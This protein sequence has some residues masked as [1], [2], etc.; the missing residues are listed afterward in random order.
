MADPENTVVTEQIATS[1][2]V[3]RQASVAEL[4]RQR[5]AQRD[6]A[7]VIEL[8]SGLCVEVKRPD[9][10]ALIE[11]GHIP[12]DI[13]ASMQATDPS[14]QKLD[15]AQIDKYMQLLSLITR[16]AVVSPKIAAEGA[17]PAD[18]DITLD[19]LDSMD[20]NYIMDYIQTGVA[21]LTK[22]RAKLEQLSAGSAS[23]TVS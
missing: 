10:A 3:N 20:K 17:E 9:V 4:F 2:P 23:P 21:D 18:D 13:A 12:A 1:A 14:Q 16:E 6:Q 19:M 22:F 11:K 5:R 8:P 15:V 7:Q